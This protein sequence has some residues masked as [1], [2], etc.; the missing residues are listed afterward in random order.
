LKKKVVSIHQDVETL[1][2]DAFGLNEQVLCAVDDAYSLVLNR[3]EALKR[4]Q[5]AT[6]HRVR[7]AM[8]KFRYLIEIVSPIL[9]DFPKETMEFIHEFQNIM[10]EIQ[11]VEILLGNLD[12]YYRD[13]KQLVPTTVKNYFEK[14]HSE[15]IETFYQNV[16]CIQTFWRQHSDLSFP[17]ESSS[18]LA[19]ADCNSETSVLDGTR[20]KRQKKAQSDQPN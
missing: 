16:T 1:T 4:N 7:I 17:W 6:I 12:Q 9:T 15:D 14:V 20:S 5:V 8:K 11:D 19:K 3:V 18:T 13:H 2:E 10:G